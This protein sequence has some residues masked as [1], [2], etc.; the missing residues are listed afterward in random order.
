MANSHEGEFTA[1]T[2]NPEGYQKMLEDHKHSSKP[3]KGWTGS[4]GW[5]SLA[6]KEHKYDHKWESSSYI[7]P[8]VQRDHSWNVPEFDHSN[9][10]KWDEE[11]KNP[12]HYQVT[13]SLAQK[14]H[15]YDHKWESSS[16]ISP[17]VQRD[18]SWNVP[19]FDHSNEK[20]WD[21]ETKNPTHY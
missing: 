12:T 5:G 17:Y 13:P 1:E 18:H 4:G 15:K 20:K 9:E 3:I 19:E 21:E 7:S 11:T 14:E 8:Y 10:K 16:Y 2:A 6:Q